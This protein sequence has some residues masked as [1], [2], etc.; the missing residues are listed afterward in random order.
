MKVLISSKKAMEVAKKDFCWTQEGE[1]LYLGMVCDSC[2]DCGCDRSF[3]GIKSM[4]ATTVAEIVEMDGIEA[5]NK[6]IDGMEK[7]GWTNLMDKETLLRDFKD[8]C[9]SIEQMEVGKLVRVK[10]TP[11]SFS[12]IVID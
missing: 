1:L 7:A 6:Y 2:N 9:L 8:L 12:I 10:S 3:S 4:K 11:D 5:A